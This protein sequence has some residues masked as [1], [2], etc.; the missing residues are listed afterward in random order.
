M[1]A[2]DSHWKLHIQFFGCLHQAILLSF[3]DFLLSFLSNAR[4]GR[5]N[6]NR[7]HFR[8]ISL[9]LLMSR[10]LARFCIYVQFFSQVVVGILRMEVT[11][12]RRFS[13][14][15]LIFSIFVN[16]WFVHW[17]RIIVCIWIR[18]LQNYALTSLLVLWVL[19]HALFV[20]ITSQIFWTNSWVVIFNYWLSMLNGNLCIWRSAYLASVVFDYF[21]LG[22]ASWKRHW[23]VHLCS[24]NVRNC[25]SIFDGCQ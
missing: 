11:I 24:A 4:T 8:C 15:W 10:W 22:I 25:L 16:R 6:S 21:D 13:R 18:F 7:H 3:N 23:L 12:L 17:I 9:L 20:I 19:N 2:Y 1:T 14:Y 5:S